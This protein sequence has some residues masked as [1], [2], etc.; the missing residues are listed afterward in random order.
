[1]ITVKEIAELAGVSRKTAERALSGVTKDKRS[2]AR[3]RAEKVREIAAAYG[4]QPSEVALSLRRGS[5]RTIGF[6]VDILTDQFL[7]AAAETAI[8]EADRHGFKVALQVVKFSPELTGEVFKNF[9]A[10]G[11]DAVITSC[12]SSQL[13]PELMANCVQRKYPVLTLCGRSEYDLSSASVDYS[14]ALP[15]AVE[16]LAKRG[17]KKVTLALY[18]GKNA[19]NER[20]KQI[21]LQSCEKCGVAVDFRVHTEKMQAV[22]LVEE[23]L[24]AVIL[25]GKYSMRVYMDACMEQGFQPDVIGF[26]N[27]WTLAA[28]QNF[29]LCGIILEDA[30]SS[31]RQAV[32]QV[33]DECSGGGRKHLDIPARFVT[34]KEFHALKVA[35]LANQYLFEQE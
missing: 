10:S 15:E 33:L 17:H 16:C 6:M 34:E 9:Q 2:D 13:P 23:K 35:N 19:D 21:F 31:V 11:M 18:K 3:K 7:A 22:A 25:Y 28:A 30:E 27:E 26:Y 4:Y 24:P 5:V 29:N 12:T 20:T 14:T 32:R 1:M 8:D